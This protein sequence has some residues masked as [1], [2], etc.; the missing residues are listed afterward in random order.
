LLIR[1]RKGTESPQRKVSPSGGATSLATGANVTEGAGASVIRVFL[2]QQL[3][4]SNTSK[5]KKQTGNL[6]VR[7]FLKIIDKFIGVRVQ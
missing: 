5:E 6:I 7:L 2:L 4:E 1:N 3:T